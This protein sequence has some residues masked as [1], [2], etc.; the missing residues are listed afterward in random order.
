MG[1]RHLL[2]RSIEIQDFLTLGAIGY[3]GLRGRW[4]VGPGDAF[5]ELTILRSRFASRGVEHLSKR[6]WANLDPWG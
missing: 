4:M 6:S 1:H 5:L 2:A 3:V